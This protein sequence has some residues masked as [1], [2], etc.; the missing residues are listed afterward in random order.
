MTI[1][2]NE[3]IEAWHEEDA[4]PCLAEAHPGSH[5]EPPT[6]CDEEAIEGSDYCRGHDP[7]A[8]ADRLEELAERRTWD[9]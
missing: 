2:D 6:Y 9:V 8:A 5:L 4:R 7:D 3:F 1:I